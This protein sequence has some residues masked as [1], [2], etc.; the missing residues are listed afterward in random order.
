MQFNNCFKAAVVSIGLALS[1]SS[2]AGNSG[3]NV[4]PRDF[5]TKNYTPYQSN[6]KIKF[7]FSPFPTPPGTADVPAINRVPW[8]GL[9][10]ICLFQ[11]ECSAYIYM[12]TDLPASQHVL[13]GE[14]KLNTITGEITPKE[15]SN[16]GFKVTSP[17]PGVI[18]IREISPMR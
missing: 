4:Q 14:G 2:F 11:T 16:N 18:E 3:I 9:K 13:V 1:V 17:E 7:A 12:K 15:M 10:L 6:A 5:V 8:K